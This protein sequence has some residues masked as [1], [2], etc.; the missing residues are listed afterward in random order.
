[1]AGYK[2]V[3]IGGSAGSI[4]V[5]TELLRALPLN[6]KFSVFIVL[7]RLK[8]VPSSMDV[9]LAG[10]GKGIYIKEP[11]DKE[12]I[13]GHRVYLAP[14]NYHLLIEAD[15]T[16]SLDYSE[17]VHYSRPSI[18]VTF[19]SV[20]QVYAAGVVAV[21]LSGANQ[22]GADGLRSV[23]D[24]GGTAIVQDPATAEYPAM[25][26]AAL[27]RN[28]SAVAMTPEKIASFLQTLND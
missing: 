26:Q 18:D 10:K 17:P 3:V 7:H 25:P 27:N 22:D 24:Q 2:A 8:N 23:I 1:M 11:D 13:Q 19:E 5:V 21:L 15:H 9:I 6:F 20:A 4:P 14:Q 12:V 16:I 28:K